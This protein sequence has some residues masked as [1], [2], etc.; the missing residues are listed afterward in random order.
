[1][2]LPREEGEGALASLPRITVDDLALIPLTP[3]SILENPRDQSPV[4]P[5][6]PG[7]D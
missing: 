5:S 7:L 1:M 3:L 4:P 6:E 2:Q